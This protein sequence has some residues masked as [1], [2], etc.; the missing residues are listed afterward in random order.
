MKP[1]PG[2]ISLLSSASSA[3]A[4][5]GILAIPQGQ[6]VGSGFGTSS[7]S[8]RIG[9]MGSGSS[10]PGIF[11]G[12]CCN[13][14]GVVCL[15]EAPGCCPAFWGLLGGL[16]NYHAKTVSRVPEELAAHL[17]LLLRVDICLTW[18]L[19]GHDVWSPRLARRFPPRLGPEAQFLS[20]LAS[21]KS[22]PLLLNGIMRSSEEDR[23]RF[24]VNPL[25][26]GAG[27]SESGELGSL[28]LWICLTLFKAPDTTDSWMTIK[29]NGILARHM[30]I[31]FF[32]LVLLKRGPVQ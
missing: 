3:F 31:G 1:I 27:K 9:G 7:C 23:S 22:S 10:D 29:Q 5:M 18:R 11:G 2:R 6:I 12:S 30:V 16:I 32:I 20:T 21:S 14:G 19:L 4:Q 26:S 13:L 17:L 8:S 15:C 24:P 28:R 25:S